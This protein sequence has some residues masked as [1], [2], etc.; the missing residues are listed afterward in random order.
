MESGN[1]P[2]LEQ[3]PLFCA[4]L[5]AQSDT[6]GL[7]TCTALTSKL[8]ALRLVFDAETH[9]DSTSSDQ[10]GSIDERLLKRVR[11]F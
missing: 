9:S 1:H 11:L 3:L 6:D 2:P 10:S 4:D 5:S 7:M 8:V